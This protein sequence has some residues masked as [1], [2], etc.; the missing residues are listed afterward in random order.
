MNILHFSFS[1]DDMPYGGGLGLR[2][3]Y[4]DSIR[5]KGG[6]GHCKG[7]AGVL[8]GKIVFPVRFEEFQVSGVFRVMKGI[9]K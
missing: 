6:S 3:G 7:L 4:L 2:Q 8:V 5:S 1:R 9:I